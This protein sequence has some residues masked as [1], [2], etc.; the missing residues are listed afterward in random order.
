M[1]ETAALS[2]PFP[3][4]GTLAALPQSRPGCMHP[5]ENDICQEA[6][7]LFEDLDMPVGV[8]WALH[9]LSC[10]ACK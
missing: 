10:A 1:S 6:L 4:A 5:G 9:G 3:E 8:S 2:A 7:A